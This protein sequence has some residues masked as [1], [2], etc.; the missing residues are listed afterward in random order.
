MNERK[1]L[2]V[3]MDAFYASVE[4][5]DNPELRGKPLV[6]GGDNRGV[7]A[8]ASYEA[9][10]F[11]IRSA[12]PM[13]EA[14][15]RC[16]ELL[17]VAPRMSHYKSESDK[18]FE[19]FREHTP[20]VEGLS[21]DEAF[22]D[23]SGSLSLFGP[24]LGI[25]QRVKRRI[26]EETGLTASV[27]VAPS[28]LVAKIASDLDK[29]DGLVVVTMEN[30]Q[31]TLDPLPAAVIPGIGR[32]TLARLAE[33]GIRTVGQLR[34]APDRLLEPV[35]G[36]FTQRARERASGIDHRPV[37]AERADKSISAEETFDTDLH[38]RPD[39]DRHLLRLTER[40]ASRLRARS[41]FAGTLQVKIR[42]ADF[43]TYTR[44][45]V[46]NP[47]GN[48]TDQLYDLARALLSDWQGE[49]PGARIRLL[50]VGG[51]K[52]SSGMQADLFDSH[53][54]EGSTALDHA[55]DSIREKFGTTSVSRARSLDPDQIR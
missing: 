53:A 25:A 49:F 8:A 47:P 1:I 19:I 17:R 16:P 14:R 54:A 10:Q 6:V 13:S 48:S 43:T 7:V 3:D 12:M 22:L 20:E 39:L 38:R 51:S 36:R 4:Q 32:E 42:R 33:A 30:M 21:L 50:G 55:V 26:R 23:V 40:M 9:R 31:E 5:R 37:I 41:L 52:L 27:G 24:E 45:T 29:P 35:F 44:Q 15:R 18:I 34:V 11:G 28:K 46:L 2:H